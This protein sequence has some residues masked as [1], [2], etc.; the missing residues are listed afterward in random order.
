MKT[1]QY[2][3]TRNRYGNT[4]YFFNA[5]GTP[6][7]EIPL[8]TD[9]AKAVAA[10]PALIKARNEKFNPEAVVPVV[11]N[12][13]STKPPVRRAKVSI[14]RIVIRES[15]KIPPVAAR[16]ENVCSPSAYVPRPLSQIYANYVKPD[17]VVTPFDLKEWNKDKISVMNPKHPNYQ[18]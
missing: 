4:Y 14:P 7:K 6:K 11:Q 10:W 16:R 3:V 8:G 2:L 17:K 12:G 15:D 18:Q 13:R 9:Y 1:Y 5:G